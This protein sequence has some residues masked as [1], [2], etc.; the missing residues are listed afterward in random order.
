M[1]QSFIDAKYQFRKHLLEHFN[2]GLVRSFGCAQLFPTRSTQ[3]DLR[4]LIEHMINTTT[5]I[6]MMTPIRY[7]ATLLEWISLQ[8]TFDDYLTMLYK[9]K[10]FV[11]HEILFLNQN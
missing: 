6:G 4:T 1:I 7:F 9:K 5:D 10:I 11:L 8:W 3:K 2:S